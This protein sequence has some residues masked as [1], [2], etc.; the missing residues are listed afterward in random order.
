MR[1]SKHIVFS[2]AR[3]SGKQVEADF[4]GGTTTSDGGALL[5]R[6]LESRIGVIDRI[7]ESL[8]DRRHQSYVDPSYPELLR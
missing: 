6:Q 4:D 3:I 1:E 7:V 2:F 8:W 5:L